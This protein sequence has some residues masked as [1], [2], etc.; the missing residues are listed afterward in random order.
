M[1]RNKGHREHEERLLIF[2]ELR[3]WYT[4]NRQLHGVGGPSG[5]KCCSFRAVAHS[6]G[7]VKLVL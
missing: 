2:S 7:E 4:N 5:W 1:E 6:T 3:D